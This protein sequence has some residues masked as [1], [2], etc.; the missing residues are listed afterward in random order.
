MVVFNI[1]HQILTVFV[2]V[3]GSFDGIRGLIQKKIKKYIW[4]YII[5][6][7]EVIQKQH[8]KKLRYLYFK[9]AVVCW[10]Y[11]KTN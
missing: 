1:I 2:G 8:F 11:F 4:L 7:L 3:T 6:L 10:V 5:L 9:F